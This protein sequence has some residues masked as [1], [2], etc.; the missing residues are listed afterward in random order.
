MRMLAMAINGINLF[1]L[2]IDKIFLILNN[3]DSKGVW[4]HF[5]LI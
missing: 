1:I 2:K 5:G 4:L 3:L